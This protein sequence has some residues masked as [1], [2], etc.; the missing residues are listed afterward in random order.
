MGGMRGM[1]GWVGALLL[2][3][4]CGAA[5]QTQ[6]AAA[7]P[8]EGGASGAEAPFRPTFEVPEVDAA[9]YSEAV[10][11]LGTG[12]A[13]QIP[14]VDFLKLRFSHQRTG[15]G[16]GVDPELSD[17]LNA[18]MGG[19]DYAAQIAAADAIL[20]SDFTDIMAHVAKAMA[21]SRS[22]ADDAFEK[23]IVKALVS[24][25]T[26]SGDGRSPETA[27]H[28]AQVQEEYALLA[29]LGWKREMQALSEVG[30]HSFDILMCV[31]EKGGKFTLYFDI[32]EHMANLSRI[33][34]GGK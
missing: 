31:D 34:G 17:A 27:W 2:C 20:K 26:T 18:A 28:V 6:T 30:G 14:S 4:G 1:G 12:D 32:T 9:Y 3:A 13:A 25:I 22:G 10:E 24:S 23:A 21:L 7:Q 19:K 8:R 11:R 29:L 15:L 16:L 33:M 5:P